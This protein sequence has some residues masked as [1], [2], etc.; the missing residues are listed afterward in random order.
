MNIDTKFEGKLNCGSKYYMRNITSPEHSK[1]SNVGLW[2]D[3]F[4]QSRK[5]LCLK[6]TGKLCAMT[7]KNN[8]KIDKELT[9]RYKIWHE[10]CDTFWPKHSKIPK[11][12]H[13]NELH[14]TKV[15]N[16]WAIK[17]QRSYVQWHWKLMQILKENWLVLRKM[18]WKIGKFS[19]EHT[20]V[21][22]L[23]IW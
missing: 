10:E 6:L 22:K 2:W 18:T 7:M 5:Y 4:V 1:V 9:R 13:F 3:P 23:G 19:S 20:K 15:Y 21:L 8:E 16:V 17:V 11:N 14:L 12:L